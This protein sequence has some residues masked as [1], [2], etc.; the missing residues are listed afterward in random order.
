[1]TDATASPTIA[2][3]AARE[4]AEGSRLRWA[5]SDTLAL[6]LLVG[7]DSL[8]FA[9]RVR[10]RADLA[11]LLLRPDHLRVEVSIQVLE[12]EVTRAVALVESVDLFAT[13]AEI[14]GVD[15]ED[16][17]D[18][19]TGRPVRL[20]GGRY[21]CGDHRED[22]SIDGALRSGRRAALAVLADGAR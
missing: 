22:A 6:G 18:P 12:Q 5:V 13:V 9:E 16:V 3:P 14:A 2:A 21:V 4:V 19:R 8:P 11:S 7:F 20:D 15:L 17:V 1:M 10:A